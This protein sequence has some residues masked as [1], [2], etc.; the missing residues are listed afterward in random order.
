MLESSQSNTTSPMETF[1]PEELPHFPPPATN[2]TDAGHFPST[3]LRFTLTIMIVGFLIFL[4][5]INPAMFGLD[6]GASFGF[7]Q[8]ITMVLGLGIFTWCAVLC[9]LLFWNG[10]RKSLLADFGTRVV[11]TGYVMCVFTALADAFGMGTNPLP[12]IYLGPLQMQGLLIG[13]AI[14]AIGLLMIWR[15]DR[16]PENAE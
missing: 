2:G 1:K 6:R 7:A 8:I 13:L 5:G 15:Y 14:I 4:L 12:D 9:L 16:N 10:K 3:R 11:A